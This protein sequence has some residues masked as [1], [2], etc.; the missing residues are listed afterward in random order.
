MGELGRLWIL[1]ELGV[2]ET[3]NG[4]SPVYDVVF[5]QGEAEKLGPLSYRKKGW[6]GWIPKSEN[7]RLK[8]QR[9]ALCP[10]GP[11]AWVK[12]DQ[13]AGLESLQERLEEA[14]AV[15]ATT[16]ASRNKDKFRNSAEGSWRRRRRDAGTPTSK[17]S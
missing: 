8:F 2:G 1:G 12:D 7:D 13:E 10:G 5:E 11:G 9:Q 16:M 6:A 17:K 3:G 14:A 4:I 15:K